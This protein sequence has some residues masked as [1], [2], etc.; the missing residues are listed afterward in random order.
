MRVGRGVAGSVTASRPSEALARPLARSTMTSPVR[1]F[2][3]CGDVV[4]GSFFEVLFHHL[5]LLDGAVPKMAQDRVWLV[6]QTK[7]RL[8]LTT[9]SGLTQYPSRINDMYKQ[10]DVI[11]LVVSPCDRT[12]FDA[13]PALIDHITGPVRDF[14]PVTII[15]LSLTPPGAANKATV[16][17]SQEIESYSTQYGAAKYELDA[18]NGRKEA[19]DFWFFVART[20][21]ATSR[22]NASRAAPTL[23][24]DALTALLTT[25]LHK[26]ESDLELMA[27]MAAIAPKKAEK[28]LKAAIK[29][30][31]KRDPLNASPTKV[32]CANA[33]LVQPLLWTITLTN[34]SKAPVNWSLLDSAQITPQYF[35]S[36]ADAAGATSGT[37]AK[38]KSIPLTV[39]CTFYQPAE[40]SR[41]IV[42]D[43][44]S[45]QEPG[46]LPAVFFVNAVA[47]LQPRDSISPWIIDRKAIS[48]G[49]RISSTAHATVYRSTLYGAVV[50]VKEWHFH[51]S[52]HS[53]PEEFT[54]EWDAF[55]KLK[56]PNIAQFLGG[57]SDNGQAFLVLEYLKHGQLS[58]FLHNPPPRGVIRTFDLRLKM[59]TDL[60]K[61][62]AYLHSQKMLHKDLRSSNVHVGE[63]CTVKIGDFGEYCNPQTIQAATD[64]GSLDWT[65]PEVLAS[66][67]YSTKSDVFA[68]GVILWEFGAE[69]LPARTLADIK[70]AAL[71]GLPMDIKTRYPAFVELVNQCTASAPENRPTFDEVVD[72]LEAIRA[73]GPVA[74]TASPIT[75]P[76]NVAKPEPPRYVQ[77]AGGGAAAASQAVASPL[78]A[79]PGST[80]SNAPGGGP[81]YPMGRPVAVAVRRDPT[82]ANA[83]MAKQTAP[84]TTTALPLTPLLIPA[85]AAASAGPGPTSAP[86]RTNAIS[87]PPFDMARADRV[88]APLSPPANQHRPSIVPNAAAPPP[89]TL[90]T[91]SPTASGPVSPVSP[92]SPGRS[93]LLPLAAAPPPLATTDVPVGASTI[94][95]MPSAVGL[96]SRPKPSA[97]AAPSQTGVASP[98]LMGAAPVRQAD[99]SSPAYASPSTTP[100]LPSA[101][102]LTPPPASPAPPKANAKFDN[103]VDWDDVAYGERTRSTV[104]AA[105]E[106]AGLVPPV[107]EQPPAPAPV[108]S[109]PP[110][111]ART[112]KTPFDTYRG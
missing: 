99:S 27:A 38:G 52:F 69:R 84:T 49:F 12:A 25:M 75:K 85:N 55:I 107:T 41:A 88:A 16:V 43:C 20:H 63:D 22:L 18:S 81:R 4:V 7:V 10:A 37:L 14:T 73:A 105:R 36:V 23:K 112:Y 42:V 111:Y 96:N 64:T 103:L 102:P 28:L 5:Q 30:S 11:V 53:T 71:P 76:T 67:G 108:K 70:T 104:A 54:L 17:S 101:A 61:A 39:C 90:A 8:S 45:P 58:N 74:Y 93:A 15:L 106:A 80:K 72:L 6:D 77:Q 79:P 87:P 100:I 47:P 66:G 82:G 46:A 89:L 65:A 60:A 51:A 110:R 59:A 62:M 3:S 83:P 57:N 86:A 94:V 50:A 95:R 48:I 26:K 1:V 97:S 56:H 98:P 35:F 13:V 24:E 44:T 34:T 91:T 40:I 68:F 2:M 78:A 31:G 21:L 29:A 109:S 33:S 32:E 92:L 19:D 9:D